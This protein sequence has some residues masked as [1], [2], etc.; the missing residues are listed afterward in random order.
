MD[1]F[2]KVKEAL[3]Q[4]Y[5]I[6]RRELRE[7]ERDIYLPLILEILRGR[8][9]Y[10]ARISSTQIVGLF[11]KK[12]YNIQP[13]TVRK[14]VHVI[15][16]GNLISMLISANTGYYIA[17][18]HKELNGHINKSIRSKAQFQYMNYLALTTQMIEA[19]DKKEDFVDT[20]FI[21]LD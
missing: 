9:G 7:K 18:D 1:N 4:W 2:E 16:V 17:K 12:G 14:L 15:R 3:Q 20:D 5:Q 11:A 21:L 13:A 6:R 19:G 8:K 10:N